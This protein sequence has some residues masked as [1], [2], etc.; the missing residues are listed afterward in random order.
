MKPPEKI[1]ID[2]VVGFWALRLG[3]GAGFEY[4]L[5][6]V[7]HDAVKEPKV[8]RWWGEV[9]YKGL[10]EK[11]GHIGYEDVFYDGKI[12][13]KLV[14]WRGVKVTVL[15]YTTLPLPPERSGEREHNTHL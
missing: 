11:E 12:W 4:H 14:G 6:P 13:F 10:F 8:G 15:R 5:A 3:R 1:W 2:R 9:Y 7:W